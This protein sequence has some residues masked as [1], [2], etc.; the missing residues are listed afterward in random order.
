MTSFVDGSQIYSPNEVDAADLRSTE[1]QLKTNANYT[2]EMLPDINGSLM[3]G[4][5]R[6]LDMPGLATIHT[7]FVRELNRI[8]R[9]VSFNCTDD[10]K[11]YQKARRIVIAEL[12]NIVYGEYLPVILGKEAVEKYMDSV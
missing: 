12:Q 7:L 1:G 6:A 4:D 10:E 8:A 3:A 11:I 9:L 2:R 5:I